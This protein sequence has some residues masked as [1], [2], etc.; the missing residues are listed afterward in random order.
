METRL[1]L[2]SIQ[3]AVVCRDE[4]SWSLALACEDLVDKVGSWRGLEPRLGETEVATL[5]PGRSGIPTQY[6]SDVNAS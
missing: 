1:T 4:A 3:G 5:Q 2:D 6:T